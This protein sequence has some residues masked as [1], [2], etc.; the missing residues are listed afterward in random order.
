MRPLANLEVLVDL[1]ISHSM[2]QQ[3]EERIC[4]TSGLV[5]G[6]NVKG[7]NERSPPSN[8]R[9][10]IHKLRH[11]VQTTVYNIGLIFLR[12]VQIGVLLRWRNTRSLIKAY[13]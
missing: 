8:L 6:E 10:A 11:F 7:G 3:P 13:S 9:I 5:D 1:G 2:G 12:S 4:A